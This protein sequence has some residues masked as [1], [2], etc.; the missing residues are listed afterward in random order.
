MIWEANVPCKLNFPVDFW[1][2]E[3]VAVLILFKKLMAF[4]LFWS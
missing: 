4:G 2:V 1:L 3:G